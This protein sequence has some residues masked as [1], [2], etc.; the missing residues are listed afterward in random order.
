MKVLTQGFTSSHASLCI[1][2][3]VTQSSVS[4]SCRKRVLSGIQPTGGLH[5]GNYFGAMRSWVN[6]QELYGE[7]EHKSSPLSQVILLAFWTLWPDCQADS[8]GLHAACCSLFSRICSD[9]DIRER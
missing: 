5:L 3:E 4:V 7:L 9:L 8:G 6:L 1:P 2:S